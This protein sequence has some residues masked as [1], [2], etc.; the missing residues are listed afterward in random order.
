MFKNT[1]NK[2]AI[3][4]ATL[5]AIFAMA[6]LA[7]AEDGGED[8]MIPAAFVSEGNGIGHDALSCKELREAAWFNRELERTDGDVSPEAPAVACRP[9]IYAESTVDAD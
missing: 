7:R 2:H 4:V 8:Y 5:A 1:S 9:D 3:T 6:G